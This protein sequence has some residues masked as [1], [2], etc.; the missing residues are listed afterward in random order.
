MI[1]LELSLSSTTLRTIFGGGWNSY[2]R[3]SLL[4]SADAV[5]RNGG[6][7]VIEIRMIGVNFCNG[8]PEGSCAWRGAF[9]RRNTM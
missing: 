2:S 9:L 8:T 4:A 7:T 6:M 1:W 3:V 5:S